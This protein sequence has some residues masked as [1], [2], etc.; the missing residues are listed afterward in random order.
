L[1]EPLAGL[2]ENIRKQVED[3]ICNLSNV[4][5]IVVSHSFSKEKMHVFE[6]IIYL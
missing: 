6:E 1:D 2:D 3:I 5:L 4:T